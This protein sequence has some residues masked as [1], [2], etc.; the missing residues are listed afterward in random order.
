[1][2]EDLARHVLCAPSSSP[3]AGYRYRG[4]ASQT[5]AGSAA[6]EANLRHAFRAERQALSEA[7]A[8]TRA[9]SSR[10]NENIA[11]AIW[12]GLPASTVAATT[13]K[14]V[15]MVRIISLAFED[16]QPSESCP[17]VHLALLGSIGRELQLAEREKARVENQRNR[18]ILKA[19][20][21]RQYDHFE[22]AA[23]TGVKPEEIARMTRRRPGP[24]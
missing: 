18:L 4:N 6:K 17:E 13:R 19:H 21:K 20:K 23:L 12:D 7:V 8:R 9:I 11:Q 2:N 3:P 15:R 24:D 5:V 10:L 16:L 22:I 14:S 1:M